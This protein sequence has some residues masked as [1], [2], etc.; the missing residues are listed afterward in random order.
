MQRET[1]I[2]AVD[3][4]SKSSGL[5]HSTICQYALRHRLFYEKVKRGE[6]FQFGTAERLLAWIEAKKAEKAA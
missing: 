2:K 4:F 3:D 5:K 1:I 6:D